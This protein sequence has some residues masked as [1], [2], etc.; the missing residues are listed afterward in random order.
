MKQGK[1]Y[2]ISMI[3]NPYVKIGFTTCDDVSERL[4]ALQTANP[5]HL[6]VLSWMYGNITTEKELHKQFEKYLTPTSKEWFFLNPEIM[7]YVQKE[8]IIEHNKEV[9]VRVRKRKGPPAIMLWKNHINPAIVTPTAPLDLNVK[10]FSLAKVVIDQPINNP[11][12]EGIEPSVV[13]SVPVVKSNNPKHQPL[14]DEIRNR[15]IAHGA[16]AD[17]RAAIKEEERQKLEQ[18]EDY[19]QDYQSRRIK[20]HRQEIRRYPTDGISPCA[21]LEVTT[22]EIKVVNKNT[23]RMRTI[24]TRD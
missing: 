10:L 12:S 8:T 13:R 9:F 1:V 15:L 21:P 18:S 14:V 23:H 3:N 11:E 7:E 22:R 4:R 24:V 5:I 17:R 2:F 19:E 20:P 16:A 6:F